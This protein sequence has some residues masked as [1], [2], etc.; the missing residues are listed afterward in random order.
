MAN[1][2]WGRLGGH[3]VRLCE[4]SCRVVVET[5]L[6]CGKRSIILI[7]TRCERRAEKYGEVGTYC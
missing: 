1:L 7:L 6:K 4:E 2:V 5:L 3:L